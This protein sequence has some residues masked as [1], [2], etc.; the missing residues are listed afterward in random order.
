[1]IPL[2]ASC[3][4]RTDPGLKPWRA[5]TFRGAFGPRAAQ[6][7][8]RTILRVHGRALD[9]TALSLI[10]EGRVREAVSAATL[11]SRLLPG[12]P[13]SWFAMGLTLAAAGRA[14]AAFA[15]LKKAC[16]LR[17]GYAEPLLLMLDTVRAGRAWTRLGKVAE[18][19]RGF[20][21]FSALPPVPDSA[22]PARRL[23]VLSRTLAEEMVARGDEI[24]SGGGPS[25]DNVAPDD[26]RRRNAA[27]TCYLQAARLNPAWETPLG[28][29]T[30]MAI[31]LQARDQAWGLVRHWRRAFPRSAM[32]MLSEA[33]LRVIDGETAL[34][35]R[36]LEDALGLDPGLEDA[37]RLLLELG[38]GRK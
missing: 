11:R 31:L 33:T 13:E 18:L 28:R 30:E 12:E 2:R 34:A 14:D 23:A 29:A 35:V 7:W 1:M 19:A 9:R 4:P 16:I 37:R 25:M 22:P 10:A 6:P 5:F 17:P 15:C 20:L 27:L 38:T 8:N 36:L 26:P 24:A 3:A 32:A 21:R